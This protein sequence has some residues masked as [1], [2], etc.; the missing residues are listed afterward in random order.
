MRK[1]MM[2]VAI[3]A[4]VVVAAL[5]ALAQV[6][7]GF[8]EK[9]ITSGKASPSDTFSNKGDNVNACPTV[10]Q[11]VNT[12]NIANEQGL[13]QYQSTSG[14]VGFDGSTL[15]ITPSTT[16]SCTQTMDQAASG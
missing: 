5:P 7:Q 2:V 6:T 14:D 3:L 15:E 13:V 10:E 9:K 12:G 11:D 1:M 4:I 8:S 16:P